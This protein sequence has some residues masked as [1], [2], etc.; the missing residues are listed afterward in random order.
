M[1]E[2]A[3]SRSASIGGPVWYRTLYWRVALGTLAMMLVLLAAQ[4]GLVL[5]V[6]AQADRSVLARPPIG[7]ARLVASDLATAL[8]GD[9]SVDVDAFLDDSF[10]RLPQDVFVVLADGRMARNHRFFIP[11]A[12]LE[13]ARR[14]LADARRDDER[15]ERHR[16][17]RFGI[18]RVRNEAVGIVGVLPSGGPLRLAL[19]TYGVALAGAGLLMLVVGTLGVA[20]FV[21]APARGRLHS[22]E[23]AAAALG[24]GDTSVR[25]PESGG[26]EIAELSRAFNRMAEELEARLEQLRDADRLR[27]QLLADVSHELMTPLT[28]MRGYLETL[29]MPDL[30][31]DPQ[32]RDRYLRVVSEETSR[33]E[34]IVGDLLDLA[35]LEGGGIELARAAVPVRSLFERVAERHAVVLQQ[36]HIALETIVE[37]GADQVYGDPRRLEQVLQNLVANA[38]RHTPDD[39]R[40]ALG[41]STRD[42]EIHLQVEDSGPGIAPEHLPLVFDRF[43]KADAARGAGSGSGLGLSIVKAIVE[44]HGG[45]VTAA[46][47]PGRGARFEVILPRYT[48]AP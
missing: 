43:Y 35:R 14:A 20:F 16:P 22:L 4:A 29:A 31:R 39:G 38:V 40:V 10:G 11:A 2:P 36:R 47:R 44:A 21:L 6:I 45:R 8:E 30:V 27:R 9:P 32:L 33:L 3:S 23:R 28:A 25:A 17:R 19:R 5:W 37:P 24:A 18:V 46:S 42:G 34:A 26:D 48:G 13:T 41:A 1:S 12:L 7:L 15:A